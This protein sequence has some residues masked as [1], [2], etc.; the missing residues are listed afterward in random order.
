[1]TL[2]WLLFIVR[3]AQSKG[4]GKRESQLKLRLDQIGLA[5]HGYEELFRLSIDVGRPSPL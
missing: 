5:G 3:L 1:M 2:C 4:S